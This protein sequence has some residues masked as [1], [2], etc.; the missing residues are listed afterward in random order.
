MRPPGCSHSMFNS[1]TRRSPMYLLSRLCL[2]WL[3]F[4]PSTTPLGLAAP[5]RSDHREYRMSDPNVIFQHSYYI[6]NNFNAILYGAH[7]IP[8]SPF[9]PLRRH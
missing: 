3:S 5:G 9:T 6:G 1:N 2:V 4:V 8:S 7:L